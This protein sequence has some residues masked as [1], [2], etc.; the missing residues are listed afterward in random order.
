LLIVNRMS[1]TSDS[2]S[3]ANPFQIARRAAGEPGII[4]WVLGVVALCCWWA[5]LRLRT[6]PATA[7]TAI[8][9]VALLGLLSGEAR[10]GYLLP[11]AITISICG[12]AT[13][14]SKRFLLALIASMVAIGLGL[15]PTRFARQVDFYSRFAPS[16]V[17]SAG[18]WLS[19][20]VAEADI[21]LCAPVDGVPTGWWLEAA[22][23]NTLVASRDDWLFFQSERAEAQ[24][25]NDL[26][27]SAD[28]PEQAD[29]G[30]LI[31]A[32]V[33]WVV[34][35]DGWNGYKDYSLDAAIDSG[36]LLVAFR[37]HNTLVLEVSGVGV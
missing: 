3:R 35:P 12:A 9:L 16:G 11:T 7:I 2:V 8:N 19:T 10:F 26:L 36:E 22:G 14:W 13:L 21:V 6:P 27:T 25:A 33:K 4:W 24:L 32:G 29:I 20:H 31:V 37:S 23:I 30:R 28:W 17:L 18:D 5:S 1:V 34:I 15:A